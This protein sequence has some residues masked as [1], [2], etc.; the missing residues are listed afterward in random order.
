MEFK[1]YE[2]DSGVYVASSDAKGGLFWYGR[3]G[4]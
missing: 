4:G 3:A 2:I 1:V